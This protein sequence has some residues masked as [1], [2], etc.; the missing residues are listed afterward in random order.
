M[1]AHATFVLVQGAWGSSASWTP[2]AQLLRAAGHTVYVPSLTGL[3][4][5]RHLFSGDVNLST[6]VG[7]VAGLIEA[8]GL[9]NIILCGHS[10]GGMVITGVAECMAE[11]I[12]GLVYLDAFLPQDGQS[13][14]DLLP[15]E[16][17][18]A[19]IQA[20]G[21]NGGIG[22]PPVPRP[23][24]GVPEKYR[25]YLRGRAM[26][27]IGTL[28]EKARVT[29]ASEAIARR[30]YVSATVDQAP[31]FAG[32]YDRVKNDPKWTTATIDTGHLL[33]LED[34]EGTAAILTDFAGSTP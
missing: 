15:P 10:Y 22:V 28:V 6:H 32:A 11:R 21:E 26:Q 24:D 7:D 3:G 16:N 17:M 23:T 14:F 30:I 13:L 25:H 1:T 27:P 34:P 19:N 20:A 4:E 12:D 31:Q 5:R 33:Q 9:T 8:E 2:V 29:A 18:L